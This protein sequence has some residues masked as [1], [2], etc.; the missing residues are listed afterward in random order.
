[1]KN[2]FYVTDKKLINQIRKGAVFTEDFNEAF[3]QALELDTDIYLFTCDDD[4]YQTIF[5]D[6]HKQNLCH[7]RLDCCD[8]LIISKSKWR[9][10]L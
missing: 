10:C 8:K 1:M 4:M 6:L 2:L 9:E 3:R 7:I 5:N